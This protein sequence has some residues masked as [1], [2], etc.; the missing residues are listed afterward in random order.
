MLNKF[1]DGQAGGTAKT[2]E[3]YHKDGL[4][5]LQDRITEMAHNVVLIYLPTMKCHSYIPSR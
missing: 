3:E 1:T 2:K 4:D 5:H